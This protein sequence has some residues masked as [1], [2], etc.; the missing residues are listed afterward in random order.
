M[1]TPQAQACRRRTSLCLS[2]SWPRLQGGSL[3]KSDHADGSWQAVAAGSCMKR[4][5]PC[6]A[7]QLPASCRGL[8]ERVHGAALT[9]RLDWLPL[10]V[11][12]LQ[13]S[14]CMWLSLPLAVAV[15]HDPQAM[16]Q[17]KPELDCD[18]AQVPWGME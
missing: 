10:L 4:A 11:K 18:S 14:A 9:N 6:R 15:A 3:Q 12:M 5:A 8:A 17:G 16:G 2:H 13:R 1:V 7:G